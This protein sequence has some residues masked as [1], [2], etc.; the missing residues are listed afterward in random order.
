MMNS[1]WRKSTFSGDTGGA[2]VELADLGPDG[3]GLRDSKEGEASPILRL[4][5]GQLA[6]LIESVKAGDLDHLT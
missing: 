4:T 3:I 6:E 5:R 2:C 1:A